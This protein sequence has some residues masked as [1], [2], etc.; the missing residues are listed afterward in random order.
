V[1]PGSD[2]SWHGAS[3]GC[4]PA[5]GLTIGVHLRAA[6]RLFRRD[7]VWISAVA[8]TLAIALASVLATF[9]V[10][11]AALFHSLPYPRADRLFFI[12]DE[13][14]SLEPM[15]LGVSDPEIFDYRDCERRLAELAAFD[16]GHANMTL[17]LPR[18][19]TAA[20][21][22]ANY[23]EVI[24][25]QP[26]LGRGFTA[27]EDRPHAPRV[28][29]V[30]H[31]LWQSMVPAK[32]GL[33]SGTNLLIDGRSYRLVG[34]MPADF[35][36]PS[37]LSANRETD[38]IFPLQLDPGHL[39]PRDNPALGVLGRLR[40]GATLP[41]AARE[42]DSLTARLRGQYPRYYPAGLG[43]DILAVALRDEIVGDAKT[44]LLIVLAAAG[45]VY[46]IALSNASGLILAKLER[47]RKELGLRQALGASR[48]QLLAQ[49]IVEAGAI[50]CISCLPGVALAFA[51]CRIVVATDAGRALPRFDVVAPDSHVGV[52]LALLLLATALV[53]AVIPLLQTLRGGELRRALHDEGGGTTVG[54][55]TEVFRAIMVVVQVGLA[56]TLLT[57]AT[58]LYVSQRNLQRVDLGFKTD[59][60]LL[61]ELDLPSTYD[62]PQR[63]ISLFA[64]GLSRIRELP[65]VTAACLLVFV[66]LADTANVWPIAVEG[67]KRSP[68]VAPTTVDVQVV[69][70]GCLRTLQIPLL[71]G[72]DLEATDDGHRE[73][74][75]LVSAALARSLW[76]GDDPIGRRLQPKVSTRS[77]WARVAGIVGDVRQNSVTG[78]PRPTMY[79][80]YRQ[81]PA[82][83]DFL[84]SSMTVAVRSR[85]EPAS[86]V[87]SV[88]HEISSL[89]P[90]LPIASVR[91]LEEVAAA[92]TGRQRFAAEIFAVFAAVA[93]GITFL[94]IF[95]LVAQLVTRRTREVAIRI[96]LG[97]DRREILSLIVGEGLR[98]TAMGVVLG[99]LAAGALARVLAHLLYGLGG[100]ALG[101]MACGTGALLV[102]AAA[103]ACV[104]PAWS[105][106][107]TPPALTMR[108]E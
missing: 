30:S 24:G 22:S 41:Q 76:P 38:V 81:V 42:L 27:E 53:L 9:T 25:V 61:L 102:V 83:A 97:A 34:V 17:D 39:R 78:A 54:K 36:I 3:Q 82:F 72:A 80:S 99:L 2:P 100:L 96:A 32:R 85:L 10:V 105:A 106:A 87:T 47:R 56:C 92:A 98:L 5:A 67:R 15:P 23:F 13:F 70:G 35:R 101:A 90:T 7:P 91:R 11:N 6:A 14:K 51:V 74:T 77:A 69:S 33:A 50:T 63:A 12:H 62:T 107:K 58:A 19:L 75:V 65:G 28:V 18:Q 37:D 4:S 31:R 16:S 60:V 57:G 26:A 94:G 64:A 68:E 20:W 52:F 86:L 55:R 93:F 45:F 49:L 108:R 66:P 103:S 73:P 29:V 46:L 59:Q 89:D 104:A 44:T 88:R 8:L 40:P 84:A 48:R 79:V 43:F 95:S 71:R 21:V 1:L